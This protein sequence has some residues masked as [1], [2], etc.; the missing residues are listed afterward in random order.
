MQNQ[1]EIGEMGPISAANRLPAFHFGLVGL[2]HGL[3]LLD[4]DTDGMGCLG[5]GQ[6]L[7]SLSQGLLGVPQTTENGQ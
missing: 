6:M 2:D 3:C 7:L 1:R 4:F 5:P